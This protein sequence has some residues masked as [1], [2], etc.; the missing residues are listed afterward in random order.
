MEQSIFCPLEGLSPLG[1]LN[2]LVEEDAKLLAPG[3]FG[4]GLQ[5]RL[6]SVLFS[7]SLLN[8]SGEKI[9]SVASLASSLTNLTKS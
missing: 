4:F 2:F 9:G 7:L 1:V 6:L 3:S 8:D 5:N